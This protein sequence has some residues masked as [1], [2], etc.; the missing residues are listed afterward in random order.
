MST[1]FPKTGLSPEE[2][3]F[4]LNDLVEIG[5]GPIIDNQ[6]RTLIDILYQRDEDER[7]YWLS[8]LDTISEKEASNIISEFSA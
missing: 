3:G 4:S 2:S 8:Q 5:D 1:M 6:R 7:E